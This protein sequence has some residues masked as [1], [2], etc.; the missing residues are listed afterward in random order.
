MPFTIGPPVLVTI[1]VRLLSTPAGDTTVVLPP[2]TVLGVGGVI[3]WENP[4]S[5]PVDLT[6]DDPAKVVQ[7]DE[8]CAIF[9]PVSPE[10]FCTG[11]DMSPFAADAS[12]PYLN[13]RVRRFPVPGTYH[14]QS[15]LHGTTGT[16]VVQ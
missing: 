5:V 15:P 9:G 12:G 7:Y 6:F 10:A 11:G 13:V 1:E 4:T 8:L 3:W 16:I 2:T 14:Y